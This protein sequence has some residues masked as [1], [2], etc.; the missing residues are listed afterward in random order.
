[1]DGLAQDVEK[2]NIK[3]MCKIKKEMEGKSSGSF[4]NQAN[5]LISISFTRNMRLIIRIRNIV[6]YCDTQKERERVKESQKQHCLAMAV[7]LWPVEMNEMK[8]C[9]CFF[10]FSTTENHIQHKATD[11]IQKDACF[12]SIL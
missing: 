6:R 4:P 9:C 3:K 1:M 12:L 7:K 5:C 10:Y 11:A 2:L 8:F